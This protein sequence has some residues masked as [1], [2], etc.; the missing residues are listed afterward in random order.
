MSDSVTC[1]AFAW[2]SAK[3]MEY[4]LVESQRDVL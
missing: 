2:I 1:D 4:P 3:V